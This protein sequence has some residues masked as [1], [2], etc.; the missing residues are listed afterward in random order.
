MQTGRVATICAVTDD[1]IIEGC[2]RG[3]REAQRT[4]YAQTSERV[5]RLLARMT[6][7]EQDAF[8][9]AQDTYL[10]AFERIHQFDGAAAL[11][12]WLYQIALNEALKFLR[13]RKQR[14]AGLRRNERSF[15]TELLTEDSDVRLDIQEAVSQLPE[16][17]RALIVLRYFEG[18]GYAEMA[19]VLDKSQGTIASGLNRARER[20]R[21]LLGPDP[22]ETEE[23][24]S[25][26][27]PI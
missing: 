9:L 11:S 10:R 22:G 12:T 23:I 7:N 5:Y 17:E 27:H 8:D 21:E 2:R 15:K 14:D 3:D 4:F 19:Q 26:E 13:K 25:E 18:M 6:R 24:R 1:Q 20:L 16:A